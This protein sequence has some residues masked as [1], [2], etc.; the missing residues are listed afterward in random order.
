MIIFTSVVEIFHCE[1]SDSRSTPQ[2]REEVYRVSVKRW[3][4]H[5]K[6][7]ER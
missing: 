2:V 6:E 7:T 3:S 1:C 4:Q 5:R